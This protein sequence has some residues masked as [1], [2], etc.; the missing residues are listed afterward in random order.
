MCWLVHPAPMYHPL[1]GH[2][3]NQPPALRH[4]MCPEAE[5]RS[6]PSWCNPIRHMYQASSTNRHAVCEE[7]RNKRA[8]PKKDG[9]DDTGAGGSNS[10][11]VTQ[12]SEIRGQKQ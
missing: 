2:R 3:V 5:N 9:D 12:R 1:C 4:Q 8:G 10:A 6:P 11:Y 7:C